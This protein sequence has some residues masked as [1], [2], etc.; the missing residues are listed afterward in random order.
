MI[1]QNKR[2]DVD[3]IIKILLKDKFPKWSIDQGIEKMSKKLYTKLEKRALRIIDKRDHNLKNIDKKDDLVSLILSRT[4]ETDKK[5]DKTKIESQLNNK[6]LIKKFT[7]NNSKQN[8][9]QDNTQINEKIK[10]KSSTNELIQKQSLNHNKNNSKHVSN[11]KNVNKK[12]NSFNISNYSQPSF[13]NHEKP[14]EEQLSAY[15]N[16]EQKYNVKSNLDIIFQQINPKS[17]AD[18][19][20]EFFKSIFEFNDQPESNK[21]FNL[22]LKFFVNIMKTRE[23]KQRS[24]WFNQAFNFT[25]LEDLI[26]NLDDERQ[27]LSKL[28]LKYEKTIAYF[29]NVLRTQKKNPAE[30]DFLKDSI[31][32]RVLNVSIDEKDINVNNNSRSSRNSEKSGM[33]KNSDMEIQFLDLNEFNLINNPQDFN[34]NGYYKSKFAKKLS[35]TL[36]NDL[37]NKP[38]SANKN[39]NFLYKTL[40]NASV[41]KTQEKKVMGDPTIINK[42]ILNE[43]LAVNERNK[44]NQNAGVK[45]LGLSHRVNYSGFLHFDGISRNLNYY[46]GKDGKIVPKNQLNARDM[47]NSAVADIDL[48]KSLDSSYISQDMKN[49]EEC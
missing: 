14:T 19:S 46:S 23:L 42:K 27:K 48:M 6:I 16:V 39:N 7:S 20:E 32:P 36:N 35:M 5:E 47:R 12:K 11:I 21:L 49:S 10:E 8:Y 28:T 1:E 38:Y 45:R 31:F 25:R 2:N 44:K 24:G 33:E 3:G 26:K 37:K 30:I 17:V 15:E 18:K 40:D 9:L 13:K 43:L 29:K 34:E 41:D 22:E 4:T